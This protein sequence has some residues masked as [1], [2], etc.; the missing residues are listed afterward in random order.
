M[1]VPR[2]ISLG[3]VL[4]GLGACGGAPMPVTAVAPSDCPEVEGIG[5]IQDPAGLTEPLRVREP[6]RLDYPEALRAE[7]REGRVMLSFVV[8]TLGQVAPGTL[9]VMRSF[10]AGFDA[11][12]MNTIRT[13]RWLPAEKDGRPV[14]VCMVMSVYF[15]P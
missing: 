2:R 15:R 9:R 13:T 4:L 7:G 10:H 8:D 12:A 6:G 1:R 3:V 14:A 11:A 5:T